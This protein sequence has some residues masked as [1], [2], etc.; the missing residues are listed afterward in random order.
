MKQ[1]SVGDIIVHT[2]PAFDRVTEG[3]VVSVL[4]A[5]FVYRLEG[6][7]KRF[8][9]FKEMWQ[10]TDRKNRPKISKRKVKLLSKKV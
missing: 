5:Q 8:C 7:L 2:E 6:G 10:V 9:M 4:S 3:E 1:P